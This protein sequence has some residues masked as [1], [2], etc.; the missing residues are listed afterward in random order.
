MRFTKPWT[1]TETFTGWTEKADSYQLQEEWAKIPAVLC[2]DQ[3]ELYN[4]KTLLECDKIKAEIKNYSEVSHHQNEV[5]GLTELTEGMLKLNKMFRIMKNW[6]WMH[7]AK[8]HV[9]FWS[10][11]A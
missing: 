8:V 3:V 4:F 11:C 9:N 1:E 2:K 10:H 7:L 5:V 6:A